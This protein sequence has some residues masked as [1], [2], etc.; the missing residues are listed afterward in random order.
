MATKTV[1]RAYKFRFY[2]T[3]EQAVELARTFGCVRVV[4][5]QILDRRTR[6]YVQKKASTSYTDSSA[7]LT[8]LKQDPD[9]VWLNEVSSVPLQ[10]TLR[11]QSR[12]FQNFFGKR[13]K[14]PR[15]KTRRKS[16]ASA[17]YTS[18]AFR[19]KNGELY[20]AKMSEPLVVMWSRDF[21]CETCKTVTVSKDSAGRY[22]VSLLCES[23]VET[24]PETEKVVGIDFGVSSAI[25]TSD[26]FK[27]SPAVSKAQ[28]AVKRAQRRFARTEKDSA[29]R[30]RA[31]LALA[32]KHAKVS[33]IRRD[34]LHKTTTQLIRENQT[35]VVE[36]LNARGMTRRAAGRGRRAKSGLN[37]GILNHAPH[38]MRRMLEYKADWYG[39]TV[40]VA[41]RWFP[42]SQICSTCGHR[43][44]KKPLGVRVWTCSSCG[45]RHDR[46]QNAAINLMN[47]AVG[48]AETENARGGPV[49]P[50]TSSDVYS[51]SAL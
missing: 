3:D 31:R 41:D 1:K 30:E 37:R 6:R 39:R 51:G 15:K 36:D 50:L 48:L 34:W 2:P 25:T 47:V 27:S 17:E 16:R 24:L 12:A 29:R 26:G 14:Y 32:R 9:F 21:D 7:M 40:L 49:R 4:W 23:E 42:S 43:D 35:V 11:H 45:T 38:E 46:D 13:A 28:K 8:E 33:D 22:F 20:L 5:N 19:F 18:S 10:Q 44:G